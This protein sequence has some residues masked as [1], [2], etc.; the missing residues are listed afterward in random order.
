MEAKRFGVKTSLLK[1]LKLFQLMLKKRRKIIFKVVIE[2]SAGRRE[3]HII[4]G[5][6][7]IVLDDH[8]FYI[9]RNNYTVSF[10]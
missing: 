5:E 6:Q 4:T 1:E 7:R 9:Q 8:S 3:T 2:G 10:F